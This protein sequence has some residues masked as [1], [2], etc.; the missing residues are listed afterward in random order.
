MK[1][2]FPPSLFSSHLQWWVKE[3]KVGIMEIESQQ[4]LNPE[5]GVG[6]RPPEEAYHMQAPLPGHV[7]ASATNTLSHHSPLPFYFVLPSSFPNPGRGSRSISG[8]KQVDGSGQTL[9][10]CCLWQAFQLASQMGQPFL[11]HQ[12]QRGKQNLELYQG[13]IITLAG[14]VC[15]S[16]I[17]ASSSFS[18]LIYYWCARVSFSNHHVA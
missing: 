9:P 11:W 14:E 2:A 15:A 12:V 1:K 13:H 5:I 7:T 17:P 4:V 16:L 6:Q 8:A 18:P 10:I 3:H